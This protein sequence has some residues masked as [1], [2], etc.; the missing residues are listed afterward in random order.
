MSAAVAGAVVAGVVVA[1]VVAVV[2]PAVDADVV[3]AVPPSGLC[4]EDVFAAVPASD[5]ALAPSFSVDVDEG[6]FTLAG[7]SEISKR[8]K[9]KAFK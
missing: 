2:V 4:S 8:E 3:A 5:P 1:A 6:P 9:R 7:M